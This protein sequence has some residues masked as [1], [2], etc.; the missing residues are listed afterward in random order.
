MPYY[1]E[2]YM[3]YFRTV[4]DIDTSWIKEKVV[5]D[6]KYKG[7]FSLDKFFCDIKMKAKDEKK[8]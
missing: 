6:Y 8:E 5:V 7:D 2:R 4:E 3:K 1:D